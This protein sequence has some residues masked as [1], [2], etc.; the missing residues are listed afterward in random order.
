MA[1]CFCLRI[2]ASG[3]QRYYF[4]VNYIVFIRQRPLPADLWCIIEVVLTVAAGIG[5]IK[6][7]LLWFADN[8]F[9]SVNDIDTLSSFFLPAAA[10]VVNTVRTRSFCNVVD[11]GIDGL[12]DDG[13]FNVVTERVKQ[14]R[15]TFRAQIGIAG[16]TKGVGSA[17]RAGRIVSLAACG[18]GMSGGINLMNGDTEV[19]G[20][21][22]AVQRKVVS[23]AVAREFSYITVL[24]Q[25]VGALHTQ[26]VGLF[27]FRQAERIGTRGS[28]NVR[29]AA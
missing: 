29:T 4:F 13:N 10:Q 23:A 21:K 25:S 17:C 19:G 1:L 18:Q 8:G 6:C 3:R 27:S 26:G 20:G 22:I 11:A 9:L 14:F 5:R 2:V 15:V 16:Q 12:V 7:R 28:R 24:P